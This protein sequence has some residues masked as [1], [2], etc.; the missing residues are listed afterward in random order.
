MSEFGS[1]WLCRGMA[2]SHAAVQLSGNVQER[3]P[4]CGHWFWVQAPSC[5]SFL[6]NAHTF[7]ICAQVAGT[8]V[9]RLKSDNAFLSAKVTV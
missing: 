1:G 7:T 6:P 4:E 8:P 3:E 2:Q 9:D 5:P